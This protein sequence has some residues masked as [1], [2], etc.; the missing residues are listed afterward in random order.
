VLS[1][2]GQDLESEAVGV[3]FGDQD[4]EQGGVSN[5]D[6]PDGLWE[7]DDTIQL[8]GEEE[9]AG[10]QVN[11]LMVRNRLSFCTRSSLT[12]QRVTGLHTGPHR[13]RAHITTRSDP[14]CP[15]ATSLE[16]LL[17]AIGF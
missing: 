9:C 3:L 1:E 15:Y 14:C 4:K 17:D 8:N 12:R 7:K 13:K 10:Y 5:R 11:D 6:E 2:P 16:P